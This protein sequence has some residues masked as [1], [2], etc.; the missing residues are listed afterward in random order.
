MMLLANWHNNKNNNFGQS[1]T[2]NMNLNKNY[3]IKK[4][5]SCRLQNNNNNKKIIKSF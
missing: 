1:C 3:K 5:D 2:R 4:I